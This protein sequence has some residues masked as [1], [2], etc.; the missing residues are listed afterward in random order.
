MSDTTAYIVS[1]E[2]CNYT[3]EYVDDIYL[4]LDD[5]INAYYSI[6]Q[7]CKDGLDDGEVDYVSIEQVTVT[8]DGG[9]IIDYQDDNQVIKEHTFNEPE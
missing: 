9:E 4:D 6:V 3:H 7:D 5:A 2:E 1:C 8:L